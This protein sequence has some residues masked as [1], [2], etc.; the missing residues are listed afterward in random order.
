MGHPLID[1]IAA[2]NCAVV[3]PSE[4][5]PH[6][7]LLL[8]KLIHKYLDTSAFRCV[9]GEIPETTAL[10]QLPWAHI[11]YTGSTMVGKIVMSAAAKKLVPCT[12]ELGGK[13]PVVVEKT[14]D[15]A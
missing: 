7:A 9:Q 12:L 2:G 14:A 8:E 1:V 6:S 11:M 13:S 4:L 3:K 5:S 15:V 10:L